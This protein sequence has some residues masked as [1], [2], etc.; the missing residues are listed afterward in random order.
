MIWEWTCLIFCM[1]VHLERRA[2]DGWFWRS[3]YGGSE[4]GGKW[5][6]EGER[7]S[8]DGGSA[9]VVPRRYKIDEAKDKDM[10]NFEI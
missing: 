2:K 8:E 6:M 5:R 10:E 1:F 7:V 9:I 3:L 4:D